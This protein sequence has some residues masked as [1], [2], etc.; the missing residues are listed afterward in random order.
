MNEIKE[1]IEHLRQELNEHNYNYYVLNA[2]VISDREFDRMMEE[3]QQLEKEYPQYSDPNSPTQRV[4]NDINKAFTQVKHKYPML[5]LG[6]TYTIDEVASFYDRVR[7]GLNEDFRIV[8]E[9]KYDGTSISL[10]YRHGKLLRAV[11][12][13]DGVQG[14]D[15][16]ENVKTIRSIPLQL[17]GTGYPDEFEIRGEILMPWTVFEQLNAEREREEETLFANPRNAASGTLKLQNSAIVAS[18]NLDAYLYYLLGEDLPSDDHYENLQ[19]ARSWGFKISDAMQVCHSL[20]EMKAFID[21]W[22]VNRKNLPVATDGIVFKVASLRQQKNLGYTA[23]SP[24]WAMAYKFQAEQALTR[25]NSVSYQVGRTGTVTPVANLDPVQLSGTVVKRASLHN[26]DIIQSLDLHIGDM[27]FVEK[28]GEIIPKITGVDFDARGLLIGEKVTFIKQCPECG[29][30][31]VRYEGEAAHYCP[32]EMGCPPQIKGRIEHYISRRAMDIDG[33]GPETIDLF[34]R[35]GMVRT[36]ADLYSLNESE[37]ASLE[38]LGEKSARNII[39]AVD[40]SLQVPFERVL[41]ALGIRFVGETVAKKLANSFVSI[42]ALEAATLDDLVDVD[43]IG[44]RIAQ[45]IRAYFENEQN[46]NLIKRLKEAG[47]QMRISEDRLSGFTDKLD[48]ATIVISGTFTHHS[49]DEY[50]QMIEQHG[51]KNTGSVSAKTTYLLAG[52]NMGPAKLEKARKLGIKIISE[53]DFLQMI[54]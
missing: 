27:V 42:E 46:R 25:L 4:G 15:V 41:F 54:Q 14:D 31:L 12:R 2:P 24:R 17:R 1:K 48:G 53:E 36:V 6:N 26:D 13:G 21:Y 43:E 52:E 39:E 35:L 34:Y 8:G 44:P 47:V 7:S 11:T 45:S 30:P 19:I 50:R 49:R 51:G 33:L 23:K 9:L 32:N 38:R 20:E 5:S 37:I 10:T 18:R 40:R 29:T 3:L 28:G 22:D 16:T